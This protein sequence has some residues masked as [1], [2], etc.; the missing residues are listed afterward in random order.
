MDV[1]IK[2]QSTLWRPTKAS[3]EGV[4][5]IFFIGSGRKPHTQWI[6]IVPLVK[7]AAEM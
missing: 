3:N 5:W 7:K 1:V 4:Q 6:I 2:D